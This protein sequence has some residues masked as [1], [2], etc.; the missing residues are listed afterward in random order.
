MK[1][2]FAKKD[3]FTRYSGNPIITVYDIP[4]SANA[5]FNAGAIKYKNEYL[6]LLRVEDRQGKSHLTVARSSDGKTN[7]KIEKSPLIYPQPTVFIYEEFGCE[8]PRI[9]YIPEDDYY[10]ITYTA[11]SRY[12]PAV[13]LARTR[14]FK[15][16][17][18]LGL[19][20]PPNNKD[21]VLF[22]EKINGK[23]AMLHRPVAG[24]IEHIWIAYSSD[25]IHWGNHEV[26]LVEKGGPWWDGFKVG[27]G[28]VPIKTQEGW[29]IIY[30]GVKMMPSGPIYRL[31]AALLDLENPAKVKKRCPEWLLSPQEV[32]ERIGDVNNVVFTC[33]AIVE[34]NQIYL[35][36]GAA[37]SCIALAFAE[38]D[39]ILSI[40]IEG[41]LQVK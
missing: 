13:A 34:D 31:G 37:D 22:P 10:Y 3:I 17:E 35:Y 19:I 12:G 41:D 28:A 20:C 27:A 40:L 33:G 30:H 6:L 14:N 32:Y 18:R 23:Y 21:A 11:Y 5:V 29:L 1:K 26:V 36:Y 7:W 38:I 39:Q 4:Y 9:T 15:K 2:V 16:V 25:L 24:D 8:D